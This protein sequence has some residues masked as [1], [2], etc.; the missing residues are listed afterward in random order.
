M[1]DWK[2]QRGTVPGTF[3]G[4]GVVMDH[5]RHDSRFNLLSALLS[6]AHLVSL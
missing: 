3:G 5:F 2:V 6:A 1:E 4:D